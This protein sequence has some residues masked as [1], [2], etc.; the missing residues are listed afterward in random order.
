MATNNVDWSPVYTQPVAGLSA[1]LI[2]TGRTMVQP[3]APVSSIATVGPQSN[4]G[5]LTG[6]KYIIP[7]PGT[8]IASFL[9]TDLADPYATSQV[10][11]TT[12]LPVQPGRYYPASGVKFPSLVD[13]SLYLVFMVPGNI[14]AQ[15]IAVSLGVC[16]DPNASNVDNTGRPALFGASIGRLIPGSS[17]VDNSDLVADSLSPTGP[18]PTVPGTFEQFTII[19]GGRLVPGNL[20][21]LRVARRA[22]SFPTLDFSQTDLLLISL[23]ILT[24]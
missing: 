14:G 17:T 18:L 2:A 22:G 7:P 8:V 21:L 9:G 6:T 23:S 19:A 5:A 20:H 12:N 16:V 10:G 15:S 1:A 11:L 3:I 24:A 13:T 4:P